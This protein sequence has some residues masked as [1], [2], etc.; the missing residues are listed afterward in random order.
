MSTLDK[1]AS[2]GNRNDC[3]RALAAIADLL[4]YKAGFEGRLRS[5][6]A[7]NKDWIPA[8]RILEVQ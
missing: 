1:A 5:G 2:D 3:T 6:P 8:F 7:L 4:A